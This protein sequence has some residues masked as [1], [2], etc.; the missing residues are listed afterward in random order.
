LIA[1]TVSSRDSSVPTSA[2]MSSRV[3]SNAST[4]PW[5]SSVDSMIEPFT[6]M[7]SMNTVRANL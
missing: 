4:G 7:F 2:T 5:R 1:R 6:R 3:R